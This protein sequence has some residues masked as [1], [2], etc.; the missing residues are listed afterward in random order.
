MKPPI[1]QVPD[2]E[3][4]AL[5]PGQVARL[6]EA[7]R[8]EIVSGV[9]APGAS[10]GQEDIAERFGVSRMP[11]RE[12]IRHLQALGFVTVEANR[13]ARVAPISLEDFLEIHDMRV[14]AETLA[15]RSAIPHL[16]NAQLDEVVAIQTMIESS[17]PVGFGPLNKRF[18]MAL[19]RPSGRVRLLSH[20]E[21]LFNAA[22]RYLSMARAGPELHAKSDREHREL[23][24]LCYRRD[25]E[26]AVDCLR[27][28]IEDA[29]ATLAGVF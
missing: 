10:L 11:V 6:V 29:R 8:R 3:P 5:P 9:I 7:L 17:D 19:Y 21:T 24:A 23:V 15:L 4:L 20:V 16:T 28:H 26:A 25:T 22:D 1:R 13:R 27:R 18:H 2:L 14:A 12:A